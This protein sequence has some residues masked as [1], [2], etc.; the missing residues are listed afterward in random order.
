MRAPAGAHRP[1]DIQAG[2]V[3]P[4]SG[5]GQKLLE[6]RRRWGPEGAVAGLLAVTCSQNH[7]T[8]RSL[9]AVFTK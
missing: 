5:G 4:D 6:V 7:Q 8:M 1:V 3:P 9:V 2:L